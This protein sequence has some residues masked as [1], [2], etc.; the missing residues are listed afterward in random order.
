MK[1]V[2]FILPVLFGC[3][4][5]DEIHFEV[6]PTLKIYVNN[7]Y[8]QAEKHGFIF[9][10]DNLSIGLWD[11]QNGKDGAYG[12]TY[13]QGNSYRLIKIDRKF[14]YDQLAT[15]NLPDGIK[16]STHFYFIEYVVFH[17]LGHAILGRKH[18][19]NDKLTIMTN[20]NWYLGNYQSIAS[21]RKIL[22]DELF[23]D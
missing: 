6:D 13:D 18:I 23:V 16:D 11:L 4:L 12:M 15:F 10:K 1:K 5:T 19:G 22:R 9:Q 8:S 20:D 7:F 21:D 17:E 2:F 14:V 3:T